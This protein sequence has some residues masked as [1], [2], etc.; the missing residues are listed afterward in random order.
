MAG[1]PESVIARAEEALHHLENGQFSTNS[2][3]LADNLP[4]FSAVKP[5]KAQTTH[6]SPL[7][8]EIK[9]LNPDNLTPKEALDALY[10][11]KA[12]L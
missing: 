10:G 4:L 1:M 3:N 7:I 8:E 9:A 2:S 5:K 12:K 6:D 11:L